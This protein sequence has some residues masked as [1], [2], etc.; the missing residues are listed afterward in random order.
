MPDVAA[1]AA[2]FLPP[3][4]KIL[5][6]G[7]SGFIGRHLIS[8]LIA[9]GE[10]VVAVSRYQPAPAVNIEWKLAP[11]LDGHTDWM[12]LLSGCDA[13]VHLAGVAHRRVTDRNEYAVELQ[14]VNVDATA[15][16]YAA[17]C[18][19]GISRFVFVSSLAA[20]TSRSIGAVNAGTP[21]CPTNLYGQSKL[22]AEEA[23]AGLEKHGGIPLTVL[24]P[25]VIYGAGNPGNMERIFRLIRSGLPLPFGSLRNRRSFLYVGNLCDVIHRC[26]VA[27]APVTGP[28]LLSDNRDLST[29]ELIQ[30][31]AGAC[32]RRARLWPFPASLWR[33]V[34]RLR[35]DGAA[36]KLVGS[37]HLDVT[38]LMNALVWS[39]PFT[40]EQGLRATLE[41]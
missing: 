31:I 10:Q 23:L 39:P 11:E 37:L 36:A 27:P 41:T 40:P 33:L 9:R 7:A 19:C 38:P 21:P 14:R 13:V 20:V 3:A 25:P 22:A 2:V 35:P 5:V 29:P 34:A 32:G 15:R 18:E 26:L 17:A 12:P 8:T 1:G 28:Y 6:T 4:M 24:R 16:L 30:L